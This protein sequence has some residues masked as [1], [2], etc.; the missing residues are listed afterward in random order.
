MLQKI[1]RRIFYEIATGNVIVDT[2]EKKGFVQETTIEQD[3]LSRTLLSERNRDTFDVIELPFGKYNQDF[4]ECNGYRV[5]PAT[6]EL[7]FNYD[8]AFNLEQY[9]SFKID[10][11]SKKCKEDIYKGFISQLNG[12]FYRTN[13]DDQLNFLGKFNQLISG[14]SIATVMWKTEDSGYIEH[15]RSDWLTIYNEALTAKEQKLFKYDQLRD[16]VNAC[17]TKEEVEAVVW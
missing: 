8:P 4:F 1:G 3:I 9:K 5:N 16:Q 7:E 11:L 10:T 2:G 17:A 15:S 14:E 13:T 6:K 12:H